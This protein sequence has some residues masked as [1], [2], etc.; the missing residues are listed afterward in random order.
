MNS[1]ESSWRP[2]RRCFAMAA[3]G[4]P[5]RKRN[6]YGLDEWL[7]TL[8]IAGDGAWSDRTGAVD[9]LDGVF[10]KS[11]EHAKADGAA[12]GR[13]MFA[14]QEVVGQRGR[15]GQA[16]QHGIQEA[17]VAQVLESNSDLPHLLPLQQ[18]QDPLFGKQ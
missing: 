13:R 18:L 9:G 17:G 3:N 4:K 12:G 11:T 15:V 10:L 5:F 7:H 2:S 16:L 1:C 6:Q 8:Q 14:S